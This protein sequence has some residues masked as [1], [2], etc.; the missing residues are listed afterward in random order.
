MVSNRNNHGLSARFIV[1]DEGMAQ[2]DLGR[3]FLVFNRHVQHLFQANRTFT[4]D[5][6]GLLVEVYALRSR[7]VRMIHVG[8]EHVLLRFRRF[9]RSHVGQ[10]IV[11]ICRRMFFGIGHLPVDATAVNIIDFRSPYFVHGRVEQCVIPVN[12]VLTV[13]LLV[14]HEHVGICW[15]R[16]LHIVMLLG[17]PYRQIHLAAQRHLQLLG[18]RIVAPAVFIEIFTII[19]NAIRINLH[20]IAR[21]RF[22][23]QSIFQSVVTI[24]GR[25]NHP[26]QHI[27]IICSSDIRPLLKSQIFPG[28]LQYDISVIV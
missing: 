7:A 5:R 24:F 26:I 22:I 19:L 9:K 23:L 11:N 1:I 14:R 27:S 10:F 15:Y 21:I 3:I 2:H 17:E 12:N 20:N 4:L 25:R 18:R 13:H 28:L 16:E 8:N 6:Q